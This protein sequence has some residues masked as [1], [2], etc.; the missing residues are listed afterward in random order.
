[1]AKKKKKRAPAK[2]AAKRAPKKRARRKAPKAPKRKKRRAAKRAPQEGKGR[3]MAKKR[4]KTRAK[5][6]SGSAAPRKRRS[7]GRRKKGL[8]PFKGKGG[9]SIVIRS[10]QRATHGVEGVVA[11]KVTQAVLSKLPIANPKIKSAIQA[12]L[13]GVAGIWTEKYP[14]LKG[15]ADGPYYIGLAGVAKGFGVETMAGDEDYHLVVDANGNVHEMSGDELMA[16]QGDINGD[17]DD[18]GMEGDGFAMQGDINGD[19][20]DDDSMGGGFDMR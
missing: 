18:E 19:D 9:G 2:K 14:W 13:G 7:S 1:M 12:L 5:K 8:N 20:D 6:S 4:K 11:A 3:T 16:L 17:E 15:L 10:L